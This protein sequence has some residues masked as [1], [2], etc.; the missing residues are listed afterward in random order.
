MH[1][2]IPGAQLAILP[3][4]THMDVMRRTNLIL[5]MVQDFLG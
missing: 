3:H 2:L 4:A 1:G 5:P